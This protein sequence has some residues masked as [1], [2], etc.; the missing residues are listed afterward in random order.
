MHTSIPKLCTA[1]LLLSTTLA[2]S[3]PASKTRA[4]ALPWTTRKE[5]SK[6]LKWTTDPKHSWWGKKLL[7]IRADPKTSPL[8]PTPT[9]CTYLPSETDP[10]CN[11]GCIC[12]SDGCA[13]IYFAN[14][15]RYVSSM[16]YTL[17]RTNKILQPGSETSLPC[18]YLMDIKSS[19]STSTWFGKDWIHQHKQT[20]KMWM[21]KTCTHYGTESGAGKY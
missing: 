19:A 11:H 15:T 3:S 14:L 1:F 4:S 20:Y 7:S 9:K 13:S 6:L 10:V 17:M 18:L 21:A 12:S 8:P 16:R 5:P 2:S